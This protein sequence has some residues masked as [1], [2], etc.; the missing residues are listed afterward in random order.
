MT[1][2]NEEF[3]LT[4]P[5]G[6]PLKENVVGEARKFVDDFQENLYGKNV[7]RVL[8]INPDKTFLLEG[9]P[10]LGKTLGIK[11]IN[12][13]LN[14]HITKRLEDIAIKEGKTEDR[15]KL[16]EFNI[17]LFEYD[18]GKYGTAY[19][20]MGSKIIQNFFDTAFAYAG[21]GKPVLVSVDEADSLFTSRKSKV[22]SHS[23]D[24]KIL[25]TLMKNIQIA[26]DTDNIY[27][28]LMT[29]L[30]ED[31]DEAS[32]RAGRIDKKIKLELPNK[33]ERK[34]AYEHAINQA[35]NKAKYKVIRIKDINTLAN[36]SDNF[37]YADIFQSVES[38][39]RIKAKDLIRTKTKGVVRAGYIQQ[40][41]LERAINSHKDSFKGKK[42]SIG[43]GNI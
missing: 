6:Y 18:I 10:G 31:M 1:K 40:G 24:R 8:G 13:T 7:Y 35:N 43:F 41:S 34:I 32:L 14:R 42:K 15:I 36:L 25:D 12:N 29:N 5:Q 2:K 19:I 38:S 17:L 27:V 21:M 33:E 39:L 37:N 9:K 3:N 11:T 4:L 16:S 22:Q 26:H 20:N 23:E 28:T 30:S